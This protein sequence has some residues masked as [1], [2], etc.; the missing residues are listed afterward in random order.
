LTFFFKG[1]KYKEKGIIMINTYFKILIIALVSSFIMASGSFNLS[2]PQKITIKEYTPPGYEPPYVYNGDTCADD[3]ALLQATVDTLNNW[4]G[5][6]DTT[7]TWCN[8]TTLNLAGDSLTYIPES[9]GGLTNLTSLYLYENNITEVPNSITNLTNLRV[10]HLAINDIASIP[11]DIGN[12]VDLQQLAIF[13]NDITSLPE[14]IGDLTSVRGVYAYNNA[15][16]VNGIPDSIHN[17]SSLEKL[18]IYNNPGSDFPD[19]DCTVFAN[20]I[21]ANCQK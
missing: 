2:I 14:S 1:I 12:L 18:Y 16:D 5:L 13:Y 7:T 6:S 10:L 4:S 8:V 11:N 17:M 15:L 9:I 20:M 19:I 3:G 21:L